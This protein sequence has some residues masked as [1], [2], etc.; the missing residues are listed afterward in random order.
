MTIIT[1]AAARAPSI[2]ANVLSILGWIMPIYVKI[3]IIRITM[4]Y[5]GSGVTD[6]V[7]HS[8]PNNQAIVTFR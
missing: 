4:T 2:A 6:K 1:T 3:N 8:I 5:R 7:T